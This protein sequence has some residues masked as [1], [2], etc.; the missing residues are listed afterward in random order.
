MFAPDNEAPRSN[1]PPSGPWWPSR[2]GGDDE[3]GALNLLG[4]KQV[5]AAASHIRRGDVIDMAFP[6]KQKYPDFHRRDFILA[7]AGGPAIGPVGVGR[8]MANDEVISGQFTG[9]STHF[10]AL[11]HVGQQLGENGDANSLHYYNGFSQADI[12]TGWGFQRLGI[13]NVTPVF[14]NGVLVDISAFKGRVLKPGEVIT[15]DD[16]EQALKRQGMSVDD[17][18]PGSAFFWRTGRDDLYFDDPESF[19]RGAAGIEPETAQWIAE[20]DVVLVGADCVAME[21]FPPV[22][23]RLTEVHATF[24]CYKG[25]YIIVNVN[26]REL[27]ARQA[28][29]FAFSATPIPFVGAQGS[30]SRPFAIT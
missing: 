15:R 13:E 14:T 28:W 1:H 8:Y 30:P 26:L 19:V 5:L 27:A 17:I 11:V 18:L 16:I 23:D 2:W 9:M 22:S 3:R 21:P 29:Q 24:L 12:A 25:I 4:P 10:N 7:S 20:R 6:F